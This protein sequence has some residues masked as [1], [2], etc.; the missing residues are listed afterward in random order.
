MDVLPEAEPYCHWFVAVS[1]S[2]SVDPGAL[3]MVVTF[4]TVAEEGLTSVAAVPEPSPV[5]MTL[6]EVSLAN[7]GQPEGMSVGVI[8]ATAPDGTRVKLVTFSPPTEPYGITDPPS[9]S[10][11]RMVGE[12]SANP[13]QI[14]VLRKSSVYPFYPFSTR[15][16]LKQATTASLA[17]GD[18]LPATKG[19]ALSL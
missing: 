3:G 10:A 8:A 15:T 18:P 7:D 13:H 5:A 11:N 17:M 1:K 16:P 2:N 4:L 14:T 6:T 19:T 9:D 12:G